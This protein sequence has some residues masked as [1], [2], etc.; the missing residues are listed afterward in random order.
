MPGEAAVKTSATELTA[1]NL[2]RYFDKYRGRI[3]NGRK[4][5]NTETKKDN[6]ILW[7]V[8]TVDG[9]AQE[10]AEG[11]TSVLQFPVRQDARLQQQLKL[12]QGGK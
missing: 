10:K 3:V 2:G 8:E 4:L 12:N 9:A 7:V 6:N 11:G 1:R 5:V